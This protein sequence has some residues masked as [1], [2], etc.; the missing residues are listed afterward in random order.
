MPEEYS[1]KRRHPRIYFSYND[2]INAVVSSTENLQTSFSGNILNLSQGGLQLNQKRSEY[3]GLQPND[4]IIIRRII[5]VNE[6]ISL[7]DIP[8]KVVW[9]MDNEYLNHIVMGIA[10][11]TLDGSQEKTLKSFINTWLALHQ[12]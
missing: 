7:A 1:V 2:R 8:A 4:D 10:F 6:L 12:E 3:R 9:F 5:G 11:T